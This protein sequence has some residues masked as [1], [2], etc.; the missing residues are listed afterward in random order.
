MLFDQRPIDGRR[1]QREIAEVLKPGELV[2]QQVQVLPGRTL[3]MP[4]VSVV[5]RLPVR[6]IA[7]EQPVGQAPRNALEESGLG[8][9]LLSQPIERR[10]RWQLDIARDQ[11]V[12]RRVDDVDRLVHC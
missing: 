3:G 8:V 11:L 4:L 6:P 10:E 12:D 2:D 7:R 9:D 5:G 1:E